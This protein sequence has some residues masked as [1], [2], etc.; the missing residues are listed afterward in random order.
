MI[1]SIAW[2]TCSDNEGI[3]VPQPLYNGFPTDI[4]LRGHAKLLKASFVQQG[5]Q[6]SLD[7]VF[8]PAKIKDSLERTWTDYKKQNIT[9]RGV[10]IAKYASPSDFCS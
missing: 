1:D 7:D 9:M 4:H 3:I 6:Y 8:D 5:H 10:I 2:N